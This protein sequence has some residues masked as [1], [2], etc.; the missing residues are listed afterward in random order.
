LTRRVLWIAGAALVFAGALVFGPSLAG[1]NFRTVVEGRVYR[2][3]QLAPEELEER[4]ERHGI[5]SVLNLRGSKED[6][7]WYRREQEVADRHGLV[8]RSIDLVPERLPTQPAVVS[9]VDA[10][11][12]LPE[13]VLIHCAA[14]ADRTGFA[15]VLA[16]MSKGRAPFAEARGQLS[17]WYGHVP[18]GP[19]SEIGRIFDLYETYL[20]DSGAS[21][22]FSTFDDWARRVYVP[23]SYDARIAVEGLPSSVPAGERMDVRVRALNSSPARW[24]LT[25]DENRGVKLGVRLRRNGGEWIDYDRHGNV[26]TIVEAGEEVSFDAAIWAPRDAGTYTIKLDLVDEHVT[27]FE[28]QGSEPL[29]RP[30]QVEKAGGDP[31]E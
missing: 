14:G 6:R 22:T 27:W 15:S 5:R 21:D 17:L 4:I 2:S 23:Y 7:A 30:L 1:S 24:V 18:F 13:P 16:A 31:Q 29:V 11:E 20:H 28:D 3:A 10:L 12:A 25:G 9:L 19:S 26:E 8:L